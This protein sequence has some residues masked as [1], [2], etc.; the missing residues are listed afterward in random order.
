MYQVTAS[1]FTMAGVC[2]CV[3]LW[4]KEEEAGEEMAGHQVGQLT[5]WCVFHR[6]NFLPLP[7]SSIVYF[8]LIWIQRWESFICSRTFSRFC[9]LS[10][11]V[12]TPFYHPSLYL[13]C[14]LLPLCFPTFSVSRSTDG[15]G[16]DKTPPSFKICNSRN[17]QM[18]QTLVTRLP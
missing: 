14:F 5:R 3:C 8:S 16:S 6:A 11:T 10:N 18:M 1:Q 4:E 17:H 15:V 2:M 13:L 7:I 9:H 12:P